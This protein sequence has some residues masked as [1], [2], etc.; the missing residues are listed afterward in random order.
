LG[1]WG[2]GKM[3]NWKLGFINNRIVR[4]DYEGELEVEGCKVS[5]WMDGIL[6]VNQV[7]VLKDNLPLLNIYLSLPFPSQILISISNITE[8]KVLLEI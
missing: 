2:I 5:E 6:L 4:R 7:W 1:N 8:F 3:R